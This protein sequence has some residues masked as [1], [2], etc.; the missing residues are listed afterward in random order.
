MRRA[1]FYPS[2]VSSMSYGMSNFQNETTMPESRGQVDKNYLDDYIHK[3]PKISKNMSDYLSR[4]EDAGGNHLLYGLFGIVFILIIVTIY[5]HMNISEMRVHLKFLE[6]NKPAPEIR[7]IDRVIEH[8]APP[9]NVEPIPI[10][11][12]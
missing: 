4:L 1:S 10:A 3:Y 12:S 2:K 5:Q 9:P 8:Q 6:M 11:K 7:Y